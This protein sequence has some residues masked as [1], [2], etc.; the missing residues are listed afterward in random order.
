MKVVYEKLKPL[1]GYLVSIVVNTINGWYELE[2]GLPINW[3]YD[4]NS[5]VGCSVIS[6]NDNGVLLKI[7]PKNENVVIDDLINFVKIIIETNI[8]IEEKEKEFTDKMKKMKE[9]LEEEARKFYDEL[10]DMKNKSFKNFND[11]FVEEI[12]SEKKSK[13]SKKTSTKT[14]EIV[15]NYDENDDVDII[16]DISNDK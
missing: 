15:E 16:K 1:D 5:E 13:N 12:K 8:K 6:K 3:I 14:K 10:D 7:H 4:E 2:I 11:T 9:Q